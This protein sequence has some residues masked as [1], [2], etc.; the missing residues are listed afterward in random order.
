MN[1]DGVDIAGA[2]RIQPPGRLPNGIP[3]NKSE[4]HQKEDEPYWPHCCH[5]LSDLPGFSTAGVLT[6]R[7][8]CRP[9]VI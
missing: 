7:A 5:L 9:C 3:H 1:S 8:G 4:R 2:H 6:C